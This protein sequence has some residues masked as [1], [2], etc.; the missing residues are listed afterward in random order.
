[1]VAAGAEAVEAEAE[2]AGTE[3]E[4]GGELAV[5]PVRSGAAEAGHENA[6]EASEKTAARAETVARAEEKR[7]K[8]AVGVAHARK[9]A[10]GAR[11]VLKAGV[12]AKVKA[13]AEVGRR[14][15][16]GAGK[17]IRR[18]AANRGRKSRGVGVGAR[19][20]RTRRT[21]HKRTTWMCQWRS[22][23]PMKMEMR[24]KVE[25][26]L[27]LMRFDPA[28]TAVVTLM[29]AVESLVELNDGSLPHPSISG[30]RDLNFVN[31]WN[32]MAQCYEVTC[33]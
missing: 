6:V 19:A 33:R 14:I 9:V 13:V 27:I 25:Q 8:V 32:F 11:S 5:V 21:K 28:A 24:R 1:M 18:T 22:Q 17:R 23:H 10:A 12:E 7:R 30:L 31:C 20:V 29:E 4:V 3:A 16:A 26:V 2:A 15:E